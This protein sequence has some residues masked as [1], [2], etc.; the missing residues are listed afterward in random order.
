MPLMHVLYPMLPFCY[1]L[2]HMLAWLVVAAGIASNGVVHA[3]TQDL[4][5][6]LPPDQ[7][8][9]ELDA[10]RGSP[11]P[12]NVKDWG[13]AGDGQADDTA[14]IAQCWHE[15][16][17]AYVH[18]PSG[19]YLIAQLELTGANRTLHLLDGATLIAASAREL[20]GAR[21]EDWYTLVLRDCTG[22][23]ILGAGSATVDGRAR[24]WVTGWAPGLEGDRK[25]VVNWQDSSCW[26]PPQCRPRLL[27]VRNS[28]HIRLSHLFIND[29]IFWTLHVVNSSHVALSNL[30]IR[31][32][33]GIPNNDG[34]DVDSSEHVKVTNIDVDT[35]D[36]ALCIKT[37]EP[38]RPTAHVT[39]T[40]A[41][42]ASRSAALK[43][44]S[45]S[46]ADMHNVTIRDVTIRP[47]HRAIGVQLRD[48]GN[49]SEIT[50]RDVRLIARWDASDWW[51]AA[52]A[53]IISRLRRE[54]DQATIGALRDMTLCNVSGVSEAGVVLAGEPGFPLG[55]IALRALRLGMEKVTEYAG[56]FRD[57]RPGP[58]DREAAQPGALYARHVRQLDVEDSEL[59]MSGGDNA[60]ADWGAPLQ[61]QMI[62]AINFVDTVVRD[63]R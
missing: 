49:M 29:S 35:A 12:C 38:G 11:A 40:G 48:G 33:P 45:E 24:D 7:R 54:T 19:T 42:L 60:R 57:L 16:A 55:R 3:V 31:G 59:W 39:V 14:A 52:E 37:T 44:G 34:I 20:Y 36:D 28:D 8:S 5:A 15:C 27:G 32:D 58:W 25:V 23:S 62:G 10:A 6:G 56:G 22:C 46:V 13:A 21:Q 41:T 63:E 30:V 2:A 53:I 18:I 43:F 61:L 26:R 17:S 47:S 50:V 9:T 51:G 4:A 1:N